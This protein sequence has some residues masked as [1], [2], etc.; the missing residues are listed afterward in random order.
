MAR[1]GTGNVDEL[2]A[3]VP[4]AAGLGSAISC[5]RPD[6]LDADRA[7]RREVLTETAKNFKGLALEVVAITAST[8]D[9]VSTRPAGEEFTE[10]CKLTVPIRWEPLDV[11]VR[12]AGRESTIWINVWEIAGRWYLVVMQDKPT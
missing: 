11:K 7:G 10:G 3:L 12:G 1:L 2:A 5:D 9:E 6:R 4:H 8:A